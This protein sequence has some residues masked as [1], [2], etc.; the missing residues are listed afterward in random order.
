VYG[1]S[2]SLLL[3]GASISNLRVDYGDSRMSFYSNDIALKTLEDDYKILVS[4]EVATQ[5]AEGTQSIALDGKHHPRVR[6]WLEIAV[7]VAAV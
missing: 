3:N 6:Q 2:L 7:R 1:C 5:F 4:R